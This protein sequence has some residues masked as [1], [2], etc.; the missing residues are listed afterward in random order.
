MLE[1]FPLR[2]LRHTTVQQHQVPP[3][4]VRPVFG[5]RSGRTS[6]I[7]HRISSS[8]FVPWFD[9]DDYS[10]WPMDLIFIPERPPSFAVKHDAL[11][12]GEASAAEQ[13]LN[14]G[15]LHNTGQNRCAK[16]IP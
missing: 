13:T 1:G 4:N 15:E 6:R 8:T 14:I 2:N 3:V 11:E 7:H 10:Q 5:L 16:D 9:S 12:Q